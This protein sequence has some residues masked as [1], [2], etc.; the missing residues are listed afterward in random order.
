MHTPTC[1]YV[2]TPQKRTLLGYVFT[3][4]IK[5]YDQKQLGF[6]S[7]YNYQNTL[8]NWVKSSQKLWQKLKQRPWRNAAHWLDLHGFLIL[9]SYTT[10]YHLPKDSTT[11]RVWGTLTPII[12]Q[13]NGLKLPTGQSYGGI[14]SM[15]ITLS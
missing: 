5:H 15:K 3:A 13:E 14:F 7:F 2:H 4:V 6:I 9:L 10:H 1:I 11:H 8:I 12:N